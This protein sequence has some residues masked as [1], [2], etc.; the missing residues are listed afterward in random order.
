MFYAGLTD[1]AKSVYP[2]LAH[3]ILQIKN[4]FKP[5]D[6]TIANEKMYVVTPIECV[7]EQFQNKDFIIAEKCLRPMR[8]QQI[9]LSQ[10]ELQKLF[11]KDV[12]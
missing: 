7:E 8:K 11:N 12:M 4:I 9:E 6:D 10:E 1:D 2:H 3:A 5:S